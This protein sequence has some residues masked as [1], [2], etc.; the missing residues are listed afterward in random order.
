MKKLVL[1]S[2]DD[3]HSSIVINKL[4]AIESEKKNL[5]AS[6]NAE[7]NKVEEGLKV[8]I[9]SKFDFEEYKL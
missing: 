6:F 7:A 5:E 1:R 8:T 4:D 9:E 2:W 3:K